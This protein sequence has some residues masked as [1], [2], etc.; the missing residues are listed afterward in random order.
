VSFFKCFHYWTFFTIH[1]PSPS[2]KLSTMEKDCQ[3]KNTRS[4]CEVN[5]VTVEN[6][7]RHLP[8]SHVIAACSSF[9]YDY[10]TFVDQKFTNECVYSVYNI[11]FD[12]V[13]HQQYW[14]TYV[15]SKV[16]L[17]SAMR[18][19]KKGRP[20]ITRIGPRRTLWKMRGENAAFVR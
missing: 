17:D 9:C 2:V 11:P 1:I 12:V 20:A 3:W 8:C 7:W 5:D 15:G 13:H 14:P 19:A 16:V 10:K 18:R 6:S 4:T